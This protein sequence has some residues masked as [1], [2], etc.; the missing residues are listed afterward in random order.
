[1]VILND[2]ARADGMGLKVPAA[3]F[4]S[5]WE[6]S[7]YFMVSTTGQPATQNPV[8]YAAVDSNFD[9]INIGGIEEGKSKAWESHQYSLRE[10]AHNRE[11]EQY[12]KDDNTEKTLEQMKLAAE[13]RERADKLADK[14][15]EEL[16]KS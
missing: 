16:K 2:P 15:K 11:A 1:M 7:N 14:A 3:N 6:D 9:H 5:A 8:E 4:L 10:E 12:A 13:E